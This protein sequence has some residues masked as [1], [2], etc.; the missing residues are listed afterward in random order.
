[1]FMWQP[2]LILLCM[3]CVFELGMDN[4]LL[5][6]LSWF[7]NNLQSGFAH[8]PQS[9]PALINTTALMTRINTLQNIS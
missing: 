9:I 2:Q 1:M 6:S 8:H 5:Y 7:Y 4:E 3:L